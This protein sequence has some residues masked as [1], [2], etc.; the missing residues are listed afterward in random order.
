MTSPTLRLAERMK[1]V[2]YPIRDIVQAAKK[3]QAS[4]MKMHWFNI[5]DP[6]KFDFAPPPWVTQAIRDSLE[7]PLYSS[8][9][10]SEGDPD[11]R[12]AI[13]K[14]EH[15]SID[16]V[17][18]TYGLSEGLSFC[19]EALLDPGDNVLLP[20]PSYPLYSTISRVLG[21]VENHYKT[22]ENWYPDIDDL[23]KRI[24]PRSRA[25]TIINPNNPTGAL[26]PRSVIQSMIDL[27]GEH[28]LPV[29]ADEIYDM[30]SFDST[31]QPIHALSKDVPVIRG[32]GMSKNF[33]YPGA[34][35][36]WLTL[37]GPGME[38]LQNGIQRLCNA[39]LSINWEMQRGAL[40]AMTHAPDHL[41]ATLAKLRP[42]RDLIVKR[43][44]EIPGIKSTKPEAAFY[45]FP[46]VTEGP[47]KTDTEFI[48]DLLEHTGVVGVPGSGFSPD[49]PGK[50][51][52]LVYLAKEEEIAV[53]MD[54]LE[55]FMKKRLAK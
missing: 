32:R 5:G 43:L 50:F 44:N 12:A 52:R 35:V 19:F 7:H 10:P 46:Q 47:W 6:N 27:A 54:K 25:I 15:L 26:Y 30:L 45:I 13:A 38:E 23:R 17:F 21:G 51:F 4:G 11:L 53:A 31:H 24:N 39:R 42:R 22:D 49:L 18:I 16:N 40:A 1:H 41:P 20:S 29:I 8:Y 55:A 37:H 34:R 9:A 48:Y 2:S 14:D 28:N 33:L 36:G 3:T